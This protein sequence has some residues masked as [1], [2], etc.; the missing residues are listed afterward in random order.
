MVCF[1]DHSPHHDRYVPVYTDPPAI[2][3]TGESE[4]LGPVCLQFLGMQF[5]GRRE[6]R[7]TDTI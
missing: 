5:F 3:V 4:T 6:Y 1:T 2:P 7:E